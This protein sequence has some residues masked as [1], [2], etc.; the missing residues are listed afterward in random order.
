MK[1]FSP[2]S[3]CLSSLGFP[4]SSLSPS[5]PLPLSDEGDNEENLNDDHDNERDDHD[6]EH[7]HHDNEHDDDDGRGHNSS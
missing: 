7:N 5:S 2:F 3:F 6:N 4:D 1:K